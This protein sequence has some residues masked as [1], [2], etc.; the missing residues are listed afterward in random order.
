MEGNSQ[1]VAGRVVALA[2]ERSQDCCQALE[3][4][5]PTAVSVKVAPFNQFLILGF[6]LQ[7]W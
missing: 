7:F 1:L 5:F 3:L 4:P 2:W 6:Q